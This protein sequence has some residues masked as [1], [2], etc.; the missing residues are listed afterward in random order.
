V[1]DALDDWLAHGVDS[2]S[3]CRAARLS[4]SSFGTEP[5]A[6]ADGSAPARFASS[7]QIEGAT[8]ASRMPSVRAS[9]SAQ[10]AC[11]CAESSAPVLFL[12]VEKFDAYA[13]CASSR[14][15]GARP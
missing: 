13:S 5:G 8:S 6:L 10:S 2:A 3:A 14:W 1:G 9:L 11:S 4:V 15:D 7:C 12:R